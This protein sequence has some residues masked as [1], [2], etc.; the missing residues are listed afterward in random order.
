MIRSAWAS[1]R[2]EHGASQ[3]NSCI[4]DEQKFSDSRRLA[5]AAA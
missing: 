2:I 5:E 1:W 3:V 4:E